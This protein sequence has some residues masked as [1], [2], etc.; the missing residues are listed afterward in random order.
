MG[1]RFVCDGCHDLMPVGVTPKKVGTIKAREY[2]DKCAV[3]A[4]AYMKAINKA[5]AE[6]ARQW[7]ARLQQ[8]RQEFA[9]GCACL[10]DTAPE[11]M[12]EVVK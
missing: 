4:E 9:V 1:V 8:I 6:L 11:A 5:H 3:A 10:P 7:Q 2:C 12:P